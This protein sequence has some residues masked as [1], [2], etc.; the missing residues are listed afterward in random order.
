ME[1]RTPFPPVFWVANGIEVLERFAYY[2]I[3]FGFGI[4]MTQLGYSRAQLGIVQSIFLLLSYGIPVV[5]GTFADRYGFK[6]VLIVSYLAY[7][8]AILLLIL[9]RSFSGIALTMLSIG[10]AAGIFKPL[11]AGTVRAV[12]DKSN[13]TLGFGILYAMV[14]VGG[15]MGPI[16][17]GKLRVISWNYA[18]GAAA[19]SIVVML[20]ITIFFYK[21]PERESEGAS[22]GEKMKE[23]G[24]A[25]SDLKFASLLV[26][27]GLFFWLPFWA[28]FTLCA[29][30]IEDDLNTAQLYLNLRSVLGASFAN[31]LSHVGED[32][33][34][35]ILGETVGNTGWII[36][37]LQVFVSRIAE[38]FKAMPTFLV[39]LGLSGVGFVII[40][41]AKVGAPALIFLGIFFFAV[42]EMAA[43]PRIQEYITWIAPKEKAGLYGGMNF[44]AVMIGAALSGVTYTAS[45]GYFNDMGHPEYVW[46]TLAAHMVLAILVLV[47][48]TRFVGEFKEREE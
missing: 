39:G 12:S 41:L 3:F 28:F 26:I 17:F 33:V 47:V 23:I 5:S 1:K 40:G 30:Y 35:R 20:L 48:F 11:I 42:G 29:V 37:V 10:L 16:V 22:L 31:F 21:E 18:F 7:L 15:T 2:G 32:G 44:L 46:Y 4:Y 19:I 36:M 45:S 38:R 43:S 8:P 13:K 34:R 27:L 24:T 25:L 6:K 9:T 14:N